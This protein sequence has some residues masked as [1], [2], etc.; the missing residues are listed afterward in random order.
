MTTNLANFKPDGVIEL[1]EKE[2][3]Q[4]SELVHERFGINL[5]EAKRALVRGRLNSLVKSLGFS[6]FEDYYNTVIDDPT[7]ESLL[8]LIDRISTNHSFFFRERDHF[9][10]LESVALPEVGKRIEERGPKDIR[11]WCAGCAAGE[12]AYTLAMVLAEFFGTELHKW[13]VGILATDISTTALERALEGV[14]PAGKV[15]VVPPRYRRYLQPLEEGESNDG[16]QYAV[17]ERVKRLVC[18]KRLNLMREEFPFKGKFHIIFCRNVMIYFDQETRR[19]LLEKLYRCI[20][21]EGYLFIGH[22]ETLGRE[23]GFFRYVMPT[24]YKRC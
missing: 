24:V 20:H 19:R 4:I 11:I 10:F 12:E 16:V 14:Y 7:G 18:F 5:T 15:E 2:F 17:T 3:W 23:E 21:S 22:S 1:T 6:S 9:E 13:D 8:S